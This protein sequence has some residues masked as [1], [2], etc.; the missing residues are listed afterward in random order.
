MRR[1]LLTFF[2]AGAALGA[3]AFAESFELAMKKIKLTNK[4]AEI[5][6]ELELRVQSALSGLEKEPKYKSKSPQFF[7]T[8][9]GGTGE[10]G[11]DVAFAGDE[12]KGYGKGFDFLFADVEGKGDLSKGKKLRGKPVR[13]GA[14]S[15]D[16]TFPAFEVEIPGDDGV[17]KYDVQARLAVSRPELPDRT[18]TDA[19]LYLTSLSCLEGDVVIGEDKQ[20]MVVFDANC[21]GVF[22]ETGSMA[23]G[24]L[25][26]GDK[27]FVGKG[28]TSLEDAYVASLP[29]GKY[30]LYGGK[31]YDIKVSP[32]N[33]VEITPSDVKLGKIAV[34]SEGFLLELREGSDVLYVSNSEGKDLDIPVGSYE[35][36]TPGF[37]RE[38]KGG[39]WELQG[40]PGSMRSPFSVSEGSTTEVEVGPPLKLV[41]THNMRKVGTGF[42]VSL[43]FSIEGSKGEKYKYLRKDGKRVKLPEVVIRDEKGKEVKTGHFEYG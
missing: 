28:S 6:P 3:P 32:D 13:R 11:I 29:L 15:E 42:V 37:R 10:E 43:S 19:T 8:R 23:G 27:V 4:N 35:I 31:Y 12:Q 1:T 21:N 38:G 36:T 17:T 40:E 30:L 26:Q 2:V 14:S 22:G 25:V 39:V 24:R 33:R 9:F 5:F 7:S 41:V 20:S 18:P 16:T 34:S